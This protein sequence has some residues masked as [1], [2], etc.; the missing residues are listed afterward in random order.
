MTQHPPLFPLTVIKR[1]NL[2]SVASSKASSDQVMQQRL[3]KYRRTEESRRALANRR[4]TDRSLDIISYLSFYHL[5]P[6]SLIVRLVGGNEDITYRHL[7]MLYHKR[8][9]NRFAFT[10][11]LN[12]GEFNYYLD[13][14]AALDLLV[15]EGW[16]ESASLDYERVRYHRDKKYDQVHFDS[17]RQGSLLYLKHELMISRF[18]ALL[19]LGCRT[20]GS[21]VE[22]ADW[23][24]G[25]ELWTSVTAPRLKFDGQRNLWGEEAE[26][27]RLP[28]RPD[29]FFTLRFADKPEGRQESH[30]FY[31]ADRRTTTNRKRIVRKLRSHFQYVCKKQQHKTD[32]GI[33]S[34]RAVLVETTSDDWA[35]RLR[36]SAAHPVVSGPKPTPLFWFTT[37]RFFELGLDKSKAAAYEKR[38]DFFLSNPAIIFHGLWATP[39]DAKLRS[40][41]D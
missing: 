41:A 9:V 1:S 31:E 19:E 8:L 14:P 21:T 17:D 30:F 4:I 33:D 15:E 5:L 27:E 35:E 13:S 38:R 26:Q 10:T 32:Y 3:P 36:E 37:S 20:V 12:P 11:A 18:H 7:Q 24:Q 29:A 39:A 34:I 22:L 28:H 2:F 16:A 6:T 23:R 40:L 25:P